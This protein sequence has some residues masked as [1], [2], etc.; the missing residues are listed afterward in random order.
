MSGRP[1]ENCY[2]LRPDALLAGEYPRTLEEQNA[3]AK[4]DALVGFGVRVFVDLT[5]EGELRPYAPLLAAYQH[6][7]VRHQRFAIRDRGVPHDPSLTRA[8]LDAIDTHLAAG[9]LVY[10]HCWGGVGRT[11]TIAGCW[12]ARH[13]PGGQAALDRLSALWRECPKS[14]YRRAPENTLQEEY[15]RQWRE[16]R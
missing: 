6:L 9:R 13:G 12:L 14:A 15:V 2:W 5:E 3:G 4:V 8:A 7:E 10:L 1:I 16:E 11:G